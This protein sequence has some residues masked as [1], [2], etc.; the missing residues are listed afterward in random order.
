MVFQK[1]KRKKKGNNE[2]DANN[3]N[4]Y[5]LSGTFYER[6]SV[7]VSYRLIP[8]TVLGGQ[9]ASCKGHYHG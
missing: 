8:T 3:N 5:N 4:S 1:N 9:L 6:D 2:H 7:Y